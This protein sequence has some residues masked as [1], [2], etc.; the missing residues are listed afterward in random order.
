M[1]AY[2]SREANEVAYRDSRE[3]LAIPKRCAILG[4][5]GGRRR[6]RIGLQPGRSETATH[7]ELRG[8]YGPR[9]AHS[10]SSASS[11][12]C[13]RPNFGLDRDLLLSGAADT[14]HVGDRALGIVIPWPLPSQDDCDCVSGLFRAPA[15]VSKL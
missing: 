4:E 1:F 9:E 2:V 15:C 14:V 10:N 8:N 11:P 12:Y 5:R 6:H 7:S 13:T 3:H